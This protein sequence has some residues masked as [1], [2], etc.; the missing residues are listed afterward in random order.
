MS[1]SLRKIVPCDENFYTW[2][3]SEV[4]WKLLEHESLQIRQE[5]M[6][7]DTSEIAHLHQ[8]IDQYFYVLAGQLAIECANNEVLLGPQEGAFVPANCL[9]RAYNA[10][11]IDVDFLV[12]SNGQTAFDRIEVN[13]D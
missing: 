13:D 7:P 1:D 10:G 6:S 3:E 9:H 5:R 12:I 4:G 2:G 8:K 11:P